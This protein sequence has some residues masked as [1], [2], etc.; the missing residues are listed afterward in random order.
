MKKAEEG[1]VEV[2]GIK[3]GS[4]VYLRDNDASVLMTVV[5]TLNPGNVV[6]VVWFDKQDMLHHAVLPRDTLVVKTY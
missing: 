1:K 4:V 2:D 5:K 3:V 6:E